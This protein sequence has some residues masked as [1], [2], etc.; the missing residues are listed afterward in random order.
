MPVVNTALSQL[1]PIA[2]AG[3][4]AGGQ[5]APKPYAPGALGASSA[6]MTGGMTASVNGS[7]ASNTGA[8]NNNSSTQK[9]RKKYRM[10][11]SG[12][13]GNGTGSSN[14]GYQQQ[15]PTPLQIS[16]ATGGGQYVRQGQ[17]QP[18]VPAQALQQ[19]I[20]MTSARAPDA[21]QPGNAYPVSDISWLCL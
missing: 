18:Q 20:N 14:V 10:Y 2:G 11:S 6:A 4:I 7:A 13:Y 16:Q 9:R 17:P 21:K 5:R 15:Q 1:P 3:G 8:T 12:Q 19:Q